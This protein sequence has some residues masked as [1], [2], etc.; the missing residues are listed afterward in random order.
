[1]L[2]RLNNFFAKLFF[3]NEYYHR[4][5]AISILLF[6]II[7]ILFFVFLEPV[8]HSKEYK[9]FKTNQTETNEKAN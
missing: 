3:N 6:I 4:L 1:M 7:W 5:L 8:E 9:Q 2:D